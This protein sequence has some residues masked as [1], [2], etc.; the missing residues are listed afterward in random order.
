MRTTRRPSITIWVI[1]TRHDTLTKL[2]PSDTRKNVKNTT[3][4][5]ARG[6]SHM[7][8]G[9]TQY[10]SAAAAGL[11]VAGTYVHKAGIDKIVL[12]A[13]KKAYRDITG[14]NTI[15]AGM[16]ASEFLKNMGVG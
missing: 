6:V 1:K 14:K 3:A 15:R 7:L 11:F 9:N 12:K 2:V 13:G 8:R 4:K 10:A 5:T 16:K